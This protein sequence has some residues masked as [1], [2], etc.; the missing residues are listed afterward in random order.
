MRA[1][2]PVFALAA[3]L[4]FTQQTAAQSGDYGATIVHTPPA[5]AATAFLAPAVAD[6]K[7]YLGRITG[8]EFQISGSAQ[9]PAIHLSLAGSP[10]APAAAVQ[11]LKGKGLDAFVVTGNATR[12][13]IVA[14]DE[15]GL[16]NGIYYYLEQLGVRWLL[17]GANWT[18]VPRR[19]DI[20]LTID[21][22]VEPAFKVRSYAGTGGYYNY[23]WGRK[24]AG[25]KTVEELTGAWQRRLRQ[26]GEYILGKHVGEAFIA[27]KRITPVLEQNPD[28]LATVKGK[29]SP[30]YIEGRDGKPRLNITAKLNA[31]NPAAVDLF[32]NWIVDNFR[33]TRKRPDRIWQAVASVEP[34][35]GY[36]YGDP[37]PDQPGKGP[38]SDQSFF[39]A[40]QCAKKIGAEFPGT[41]VIILAY[42]GHAEPPAFPLEPNV[43]VQVAPRGFQ[44]TPEEEFLAQWK[45]KAKR[46]TLYDYWSIPDWAGEEPTF[47]FLDIGRKL[48][49]WRAHNIEGLNAESSYGAGAMGLGHYVASRL[50]WDLGADEKAVIAEWYEKAFGPA[51]APM[52]R[53]L[54]RWAQSFRLT[55]AELGRTYRDLDEAMKLAA[56]DPGAAA[57]AADFGRYLHYLRLRYEIEHADARQDKAAMAV[58]LAVYLAGI[59][60][61]LMVHG[62]RMIDLYNRKHPAILQQ[63][64]FNG[65]TPGP[66]WARVKPPMDREI[67]ALTRD[68][69]AAYPLADHEERTFSGALVPVLQHAW[70]PPQ[71]DPWGPPITLVGNAKLSLVIPRGLD[72]FD[73]R[74]SRKKGNRIKIV[75]AEGKTV[76]AR[77]ISQSDAGMEDI[78]VK[79]QPGRY[80]LEFVPDGGRATGQFS[81]QTW[82]GVPLIFGEFLTPKP[83]PSPRLYFYVPAGLRKLAMHYPTTDM[84]GAFKFQVLDPAG[85]SAPIEYADARRTMLVTIPPGQDGKIWSLARS[86]SPDVP[87][88]MLNAPQAFALSPEALMVPESALKR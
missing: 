6:L 48:R 81:I 36:G 4:F 42:A 8:G 13:D 39:I 26:G 77:T 69:V 58:S 2:G 64:G 25:S 86:V 18:I 37:T 74:V 15:R 21:K 56:A 35:D 67:A 43:I 23:Y 10:N 14:N 62:T 41:A 51:R 87:H 52:K 12:L 38:G 75:T 68:G 85:A 71:G 40:N 54:E 50:M 34:S 27:D 63:L 20:S 28:Y 47:N 70:A 5:R 22:L 31:G 11:R 80:K 82:K 83:A 59:N 44:N 60:D 30:L 72:R 7:T 1:F 46:L 65:D 73:L 84:N 79:L 33:E 66:A 9:G 32:C 61:S 45:A 24:F 76:F 19:A 49:Y 17:P 3:A 78:A 29:P 57:R 88:R 53:M 16:S 55:A